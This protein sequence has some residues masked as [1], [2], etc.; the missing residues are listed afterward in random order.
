MF[1]TTVTPRFGDV[2]GLKHVNNIV[3]AIW[4]EQAR[5]PLF[6]IF[7]PDFDLS[8]EKWNLIMVRTEFDFVGQMYL[9]MDV[10]IRSYISK[11][12]NSSFTMY[13]EAW[14][15]GKLAVKGK[16]VAVHYD[17]VNQKS[18]PIP[19]S[20]KEKLKEHFIEGID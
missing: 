20:I 6:E 19:D 2:D 15:N 8:Y 11:I 5:N 3:P 16:A 17:F 14:Q 1:K 7:V 4:F 12:G 10:E 9:G 13:Q 18:V